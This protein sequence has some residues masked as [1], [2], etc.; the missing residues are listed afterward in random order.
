LGIRSEGGR[1]RLADPPTMFIRFSLF[2]LRLHLAQ[3]FI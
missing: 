1:A 2:V 3:N